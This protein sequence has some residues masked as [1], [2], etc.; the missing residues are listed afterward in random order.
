[1]ML[2]EFF[3]QDKREPDLGNLVVVKHIPLFKAVKGGSVCTF[4]GF[5]VECQKGFEV[6]PEVYQI[7]DGVPS[8]KRDAHSFLVLFCGEEGFDVLRRELFLAEVLDV[9]C[10]SLPGLTDLGQSLHEFTDI[11][12]V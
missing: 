8:A 11:G 3:E 7:A 9:Q 6:E 5:G 10:S 4:R 1:M 2:E 12:R